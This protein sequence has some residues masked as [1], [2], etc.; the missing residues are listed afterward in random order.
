MIDK[1]KYMHIGD[2]EFQKPASFVGNTVYMMMKILFDNTKERDRGTYYLADYPWYSTREWA[3]TIQKTLK[4]KRIKTAPMWLLRIIGKLG[5]L[6][7]NIF[8][9][10]PPLTTFRLNNMQT[11]GEYPI[12]NTQEIC[13]D[14][15]YNIDK[16]VFTTAQWMYEK[17]LIKHKPEEIKSGQ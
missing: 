6:I 15:P 1:S 14:L 17:D 2:N 10:D 13:G 11:G 3:I 7:K 16:A 5:D 4:T 12:N 9:Y 8:K